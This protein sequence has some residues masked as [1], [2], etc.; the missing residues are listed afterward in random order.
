[1]IDSDGDSEM[2]DEENKK[3]E[4]PKKAKVTLDKIALVGMLNND[5]NSYYLNKL[6]GS[7][8]AIKNCK[9][10]AHVKCLH[11]YLAEQQMHDEGVHARRVAGFDDNEFFCPICK[12]MANT[13]M[14]EH[15]LNQFIDD[16][17]EKH[18]E[19]KKAED[20]DKDKFVISVKGRGLLEF[21]VDF[22][23]R[24]VEKQEGLLR[25]DDPAAADTGVF[26]RSFKEKP[27]RIIEQV[28][29]HV[30]H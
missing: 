3:S 30:M 27:R 11:G 23:A 28:Q 29:G 7:A 4:E 16:I 2:K 12:T 26:L 9:H 19:E 6:N 20:E 15:T 18:D 13:L 25:K 8:S 14:P 21:Y 5:D 17:K 24:V 22:F 1:M 10:Y